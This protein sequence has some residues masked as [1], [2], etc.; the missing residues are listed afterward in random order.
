MSVSLFELSARLSL[1]TKQFDD[2]IDDAIRS[3]RELEAALGK[4]TRSASV[5]TGVMGGNLLAEVLMTL[6]TEMMNAAK[7]SIQLASD[8]EEVQNVVDVTFGDNAAQ[9][10]TWARGAKNAF[11]MSELNAKKFSG[12]IGAMLKSMGVTNAEVKDMST[13]MVALAG[14]MASFYNL[15]HETAFDKIRSG[16]SGETEPLKQLGINMSVANLEAYALSEGITKAYDAMTEAERATLRYNYLMETTA[17]AQGD[18]SR[19][20]KNYANAVRTFSENIK[21]IKQGMGDSLLDFITPAINTF[22]E[23]YANLTASNAANAQKE[24]ETEYERQTKENQDTSERAEALIR[25]LEDLEGQ[26]ELTEAE[27][28]IWNNTLE[29]LVQTFPEL[30]SI[31]NLT[32]GE[33][34]GGTAALRDYNQ[35]WLETAQMDAKKILLEQNQTAVA[36]AQAALYEAEANLEITRNAVEIAWENLSSAAR[37]AVSQLNE[38]IDDVEEQFIFD[39]TDESLQAI[40]AALNAG[41]GTLGTELENLWQEYEKLT[42]KATE[43]VG[44]TADARKVVAAAEENYRKVATYLGYTV[45]EYEGMSEA[46]K[47]AAAAKAEFIE[48]VEAESAAL[49]ELEER[50]G[51]ASEYRLDAIKRARDEIDAGLGALDNMPDWKVESEDLEEYEDDLQKALEAQLEFVRA[52]NGNLRLLRE[53]GVD[54]DLLAKLSDG[55][56]ESAKI[57]SVLAQMNSAERKQYLETWRDLQKDQDTLASSLANAQLA[58]DEE[59]QKVLDEAKEASDA[60]NMSEEAVAGLSATAE[61]VD[62]WTQTISEDI[63]RITDEAAAA[64]KELAMLGGVTFN[65]GASD[66]EHSAGLGY[67]PYD[68]Y[69]AELHRGEMVLTAAN[70]ASMRQSVDAAPVGAIDYDRIS[71]MTSQRPV[72][73]YVDKKAA[74]TLLSR[75]MDTAIGNRNIRQLVSMGG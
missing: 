44:V 40:I 43:Y 12:T 24:A 8:L 11:G 28:Y 65:A 3:G 25:T 21:E 38:G 9:I 36:N 52:Y 60:F 53:Y 66:G 49:E 37:A 14:D 6:G 41:S 17:D 4:I 2:G 34:E 29:R 33:I 51:S 54:E 26:T 27:S 32:T 70:A 47:A 62:P 45:E 35:S 23:W 1:D 31:I 61:A 19:T 74:A 18:F 63:K 39:E 13:S 22:N 55:S 69:M 59:F 64:Q 10:N 20:S 5:L 48:A 67:V 30:K 7:E 15:D 72:V 57:A 46:D 56:E 73:V 71:E 68:G 42:E 50:V 58:I 16:I 75:E